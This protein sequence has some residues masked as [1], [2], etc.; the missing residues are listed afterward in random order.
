VALS[1]WPFC[2]TAISFSHSVRRFKLGI[3]RDT[4]SLWG[5]ATARRVPDTALRRSSQGEVINMVPFDS[6]L[7][8]CDIH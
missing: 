2:N 1:N 8:K 4:N 5:L 6:R 7:Q 3:E